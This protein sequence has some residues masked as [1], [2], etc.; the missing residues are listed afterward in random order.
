MMSNR[1]R[2]AASMKRASCLL[3]LGHVAFAYAAPEAN[4]VIGSPAR[5]EFRGSGQCSQ[6]NAPQQYQ[7]PEWRGRVVFQVQTQLENGRIKEAT[8]RRIEA[9][10][11]LPKQADRALKN[12]IMNTMEG[13]RCEPN[14]ALD[15]V[16]VFER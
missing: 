2:I 7:N 12:N 6:W 8:M 9:P 5:V 10:K 11:D 15:V 14:A 4:P 16:F 1:R 3:V 13:W